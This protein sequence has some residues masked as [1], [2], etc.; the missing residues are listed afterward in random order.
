M[1]TTECIYYILLC[2]MPIILYQSGII[3]RYILSQLKMRGFT[4]MDAL[5]ASHDMLSIAKAKNIYG[6]I[7]HD[8]MDGHR[9][10]IK[11]GK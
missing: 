6:R 1:Q 8:C 11:D 10:D 9:T 3:Q 5:D 2:K 4:K 7:I